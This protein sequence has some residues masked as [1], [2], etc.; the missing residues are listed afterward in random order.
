M[1]AEVNI[2]EKLPID[3]GVTPVGFIE[4]AQIR[5]CTAV[6]PRALGQEAHRH[7]LLQPRSTV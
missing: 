1:A 6:I 4:L 3:L 7:S 5:P 2:S